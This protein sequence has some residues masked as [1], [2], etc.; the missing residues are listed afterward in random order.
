MSIEAVLLRWSLGP[1]REEGL[2]M[3]RAPY[4]T[5]HR[6][7]FEYHELASTGRALPLQLA[8]LEAAGWELFSTEPPVGPGDDQWRYH[9]RRRPRPFGIVT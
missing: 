6:T 8:E 7:L 9:F 4:R 1:R 5:E 3:A 2:P